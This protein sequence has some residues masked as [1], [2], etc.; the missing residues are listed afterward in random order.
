[1]WR[2]RPWRPCFGAWLLTNREQGGS[3]LA[4]VWTAGSAAFAG[5]VGT[6][7]GRLEAAAELECLGRKC[8]IAWDDF[9]SAVKRSAK[10][11][12]AGPNR[13]VGE[14][15][16]SRKGTLSASFIS[17][18]FNHRWRSSTIKL[19]MDLPIAWAVILVAHWARS[20]ALCSFLKAVGF[21]LDSSWNTCRTAMEWNAEA[22][23]PA[24][25]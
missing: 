14:T 8:H 4:A 18:R 23:C 7:L 12:T 25:E 2:P 17:I 10:P 5:L 20:V 22:A 19:A 11:S 13:L 1:M 15:G 9:C 3:G 21:G 6:I 16:E 24:D